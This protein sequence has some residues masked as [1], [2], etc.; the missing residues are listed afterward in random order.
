MTGNEKT[1]YEELFYRYSGVLTEVGRLTMEVARLRKER[2][3]AVDRYAAVVL[4]LDDRT[5]Q[6]IQCKLQPD[7]KAEAAVST[8][9]SLGYTYHGGS[10]VAPLGDAAVPFDNLLTDYVRKPREL[11][12]A[13]R[14][15]EGEQP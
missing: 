7:T 12:Q 9:T 4:K 8:L 11:A 6:L 15:P 10:W 13:L 5:D 1:A 3:E 2:D 14:A